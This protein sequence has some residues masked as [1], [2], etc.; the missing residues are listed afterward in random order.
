MTEDLEYSLAVTNAELR[1]ENQQLRACTSERSVEA[2]NALQEATN[3]NNRENP[4][5]GVVSAVVLLKDDNERLETKITQLRA[6]LIAG[7][8]THG[9]PCQAGVD[10]QFIRD[11]NAALD[12]A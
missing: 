9:E 7:Q 4:W 10:C 12:T 6:A 1:A 11:A 8:A 2:L 5:L 3:S